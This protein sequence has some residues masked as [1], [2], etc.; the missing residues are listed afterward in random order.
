[1]STTTNPR[2]SRVTVERFP[3][4]TAY[5]ASY[6]EARQDAADPTVLV[7]VGTADGREIERLRGNW[8][9]FA[10][11][12]P[13]DSYE[14]GAVNPVTPTHEN[15]L[16]RHHAEKAA[17]AA[18]APAPDDDT[19]PATCAWCGGPMPDDDHAPYCSTACGVRAEL[20]R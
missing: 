12:G 5:Y 8:F 11:Y 10:Q 17:A 9:T 2:N 15:M 7:V 1:M 3:F 16:A 4:G 6:A 20:D 14:R 13:S 19:E 18:D